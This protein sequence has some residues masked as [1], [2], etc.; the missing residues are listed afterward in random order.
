MLITKTHVVLLGMVLW[1]I[2]MAGVGFI[3]V[4]QMTGLIKLDITV[5]PTSVMDEFT[6]DGKR[7]K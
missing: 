3:H 6:R 7:V 5:A 4:L 2:M 1:T